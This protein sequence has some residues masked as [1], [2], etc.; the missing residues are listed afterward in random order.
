MFLTSKMCKKHLGKEDILSRDAGYTRKYGSD[1]TRILS[2][3]TW[4]NKRS[5]HFRG[6]E[7]ILT[8]GF[9]T[10]SGGIEM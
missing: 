7:K 3:F 2:Y 9:L 5:A 6:A 10:F 1:K 8:I 4:C